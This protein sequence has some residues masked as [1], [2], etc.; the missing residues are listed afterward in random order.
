M[1]Y[2]LHQQRALFCGDHVMAWSTSIISPP[3][4]N[5][6]DYL[7]SLD[8]LLLRDD[9][10]YWPCHGPYIDDPKPFVQSYIDHR[11]RR[12]DQIIACLRQG[13]HHISDMLP[14]MYSDLPDTMY[15][16]AARSVLSSLMYLIDE[17]SVTVDNLGLDGHYRLS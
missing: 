17:G 13:T 8:L 16:A 10:R 6:A 2:Q 5:L 4:G 14:T 11:H 15:P 7:S 12:L 3:D 9:K 1:C